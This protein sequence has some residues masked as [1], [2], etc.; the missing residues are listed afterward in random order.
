MDHT[1]RVSRTHP[2]KIQRT[3]S[4][5]DTHTHTQCKDTSRVSFG[6]KRLVYRHT[7]IHTTREMHSNYNTYTC[8]QGQGRLFNKKYHNVAK[9]SEVNKR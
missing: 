1:D 5:T 6:G 9:S 2:E 8:T 3:G 7:N 4:Q